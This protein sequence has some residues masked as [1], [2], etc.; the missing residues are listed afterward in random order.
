M[1]KKNQCFLSFLPHIYK[2][3]I[4]YDNPK[5]LEET[6]RKENLCYDQNKNRNNVTSWKSKRP[7]NFEHKRKVKKFH[8]NQGPNFQSYQGNNFKGNKLQPNKE[9]EIPTSYHKSN[10]QREPL[11]C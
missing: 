2:E 10:V 9:K 5:T 6:I 8:K 7:E 11:K 1:K 4:E 3:R